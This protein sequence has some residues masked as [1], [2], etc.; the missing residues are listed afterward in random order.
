MF[1]YTI[2]QN[3]WL[4]LS[5]GSGVILTI[6]IILFFLAIWRPRP[7]VDQGQTFK[8]SGATWRFMPW[9]LI[10]TYVAMFVYYFAGPLVQAY[11]PGEW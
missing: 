7:M 9:I 1:Q 8:G 4:F 2:L 3:Q 11:W 10:V 5:L 6:T